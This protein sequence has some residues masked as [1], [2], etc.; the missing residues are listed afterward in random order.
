MK[1]K[2]GLFL[3]LFSLAV[4][5]GQ[6]GSVSSPRAEQA[7]PTGETYIEP[8]LWSS[9]AETLSVIVTATDSQ[10][11]ASAVER[12]GGQVSSDLWLIDAV[13]ASLPADQ[14]RAL[15]NQP[16]IISIVENKGV[17]SADEP[18]DGWVTDYDIPVPWDGSPDAQSTADDAVWDL[19][20]PVSIDVGADVLHNE[21]D[22]MGNEVVVAV[23]DS[24]IYFD[25]KTRNAV[26]T[27]L[28]KLFLGQADFVGE[29]V[30]GD[31]GKQKS[32]YCFTQKGEDSYDGFG[33]GSHVAG[34]IW[35][36]VTD[37]NTGTYNGIAPGAEIL[38]VRVLGLDGTG[39]YADVI[40]G[41]QFVVSNQ[42]AYNIRVMNLS[43]SAYATT[44]YFADPINRA[45]EQ[46]WANGIVV[47]AAAGNTGAGAESVTV[48]GN[49]PY[50]ITVGAVNGNRTPGYWGDD[51]MPSWSATGPTW[52]GFAKPDVL[53]PGTY[54]VSYMYNDLDNIENSDVLV[55]QH[56]DN[57]FASTLFRMSGTSQA[58]AVTSGVVALMLDAHPELTP[59]QV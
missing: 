4:Y 6:A 8:G 17:K 40:E 23:L 53:A 27:K 52:D 11:A 56:P 12:L 51:I 38:S 25:K 46:A 21:H 43:L 30:C 49:D 26:G 55:Q 7:S 9:E 41:I 48:P 44:P 39:S 34:L 2:L 47:V 16:A 20:N 18:W 58:T 29:G 50:V 42:D 32:G 22:I 1:L 31:K 14:L 10:A 15:A 57:A 5:L 28:D 35:S 54:L 45:V 24:G 59:D 36:N 3:I 33:H 37:L 13:A 19:V